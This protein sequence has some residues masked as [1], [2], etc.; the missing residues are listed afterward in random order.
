MLKLTSRLGNNRKELV[1]SLYLVLLQGVNKLLPLFVL[2][3]LLAVLG[4]EGYALV[5]FSLA[6]VQF[7]VLFVDF[8]FDLS[9]TKRVA[10]VRNDR[11]ALTRVF[12]SVVAAKSFLLLVALPMTLLPVWLI[13]AYQPY[14]KATLC[15]LPMA[16]GSAFTFMWMFQGV[17]RV[18]H[19]AIIN[20]LSKF[21]LLPLIF[22]FVHSEADSALAAFLQASVY[23]LTAIV[24]CVWLWQLRLVEGPACSWREVCSETAESLPLFLSRASTSVY[25]QLFVVILALFCTRDAVGRYTSAEALMRAACFIIYVPLTQAFFP[26]ISALSVENRPEGLRTFRYLRRLVFAAMLFVSVSIAAVSPVLPSL[27]GPSYDGLTQLL[28]IMSVAPLFIGLGAVYGQMGLIALGNAAT[29]RQFR[30][31]YFIVA[32]VSLLL[33]LFCVWMWRESG[34]ALALV[35]TECLVFLFMYSACRRSSVLTANPQGPCS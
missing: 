29:R 18:R 32:L 21:I 23:L 8:G 11:K 27:L 1:D 5:G 16:V 30:N 19:I 14:F 34:A 35:L 12:W 17:G 26:R 22:I 24:S 4:A 20:T 25:T 28:L 2:P 13:P 7:A 15:T 6:L 3:Y 9:A 10:L 33:M 31:V